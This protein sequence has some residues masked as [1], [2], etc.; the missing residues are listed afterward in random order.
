VD[1]AFIAAALYCCRREE[2]HRTGHEYRSTRTGVDL[3]V[4]K[5]TWSYCFLPVQRGKQDMVGTQNPAKVEFRGSCPEKMQ[6]VVHDRV[7]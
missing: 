1:A 4:H 2:T 5:C 6:C 7:W 3:V